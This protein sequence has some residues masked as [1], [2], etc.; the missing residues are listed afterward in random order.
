M[1]SEVIFYQCNFDHAKNIVFEQYAF[2][3]YVRNNPYTS[4]YMWF[5]KPIVATWKARFKYL[6][7]IKMKSKEQFIKEGNEF[8]KTK[9]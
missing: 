2:N 9:Q 1:S 5:N 3:N 7:N 8:K 4:D 6:K